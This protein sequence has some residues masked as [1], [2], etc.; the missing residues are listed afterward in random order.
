MIAALVLSA[1]ALAPDLRVEPLAEGVWLHVS[2]HDIDGVPVEAN[3]LVVEA[4]GAAFL[5]DVTWNEAQAEAL[6][7]WITGRG[8]V[9]A[10]AVITHGHQDRGGGLPALQLHGVSAWSLPRTADDLDGQGFGRPDRTIDPEKPK[11]LFDGRLEA[12]FP[13]KGHSRDNLVVWMPAQGILFG[14]CLIRSAAATSIGET[15]GSVLSR[16]EATVIAVETRFPDARTVVPGHGAPG[17]P[18]L[19]RHTA[20]LAREG[21]EARREARRKAAEEAA[22]QAAEEAGR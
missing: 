1:V 15:P 4:D 19:L 17:G 13:G 16:W 6:Y 11:R 10:G 14:G 12:V 5:V 18:E 2:T 22:K 8:L 20:E 3:G 7:A 9:V 21:L